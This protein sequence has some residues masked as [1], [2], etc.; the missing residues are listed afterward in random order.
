MRWPGKAWVDAHP[1][2][3]AEIFYG[4]M[5][6]CIALYLIGGLYVLSHFVTK[7]W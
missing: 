7:Y 6:M 3:S 1:V 5:G 2:E 4:V